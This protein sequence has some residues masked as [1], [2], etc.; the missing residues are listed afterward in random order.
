LSS[1]HFGKICDVNNQKGNNITTIDLSLDFHVYSAIWESGK[2]TDS[3]YIPISLR[4]LFSPLAGRVVP[5]WS[6]DVSLVA[7]GSAVPPSL[8]HGR[9]PQLGRW[10]QLARC[11]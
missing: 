3:P 8:T 4:L 9:H 10:W 6:R 2:V 7:Q 5:R 1:Y 11:S